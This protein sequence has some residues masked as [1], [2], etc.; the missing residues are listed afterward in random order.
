[1]QEDVHHLLYHGQ[2]CT[3]SSCSHFKHEEAEVLK[4]SGLAYRYKLLKKEK[5]KNPAGLPK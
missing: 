5:K 4:I 1:M 3:G 2:L